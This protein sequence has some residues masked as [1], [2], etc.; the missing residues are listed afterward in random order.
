[1]Q[2]RNYS[3]EELEA[4]LLDRLKARGCTS[5]T[6]NGYRYQCNSIFAWLKANGYSSYRKKGE[7]IFYRIIKVN[8][9]I[10]RITEAL[11]L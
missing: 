7:L 8:M 4:E 3:F 11:E 6:I 2:E 9:V 1:M 5:I 10:I